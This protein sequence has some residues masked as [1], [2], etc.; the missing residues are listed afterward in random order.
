MRRFYEETKLD[1][2]TYPWQTIF[3]LNHIVIAKIYRDLR[4]EHHLVQDHHGEVPHIPCLTPEGFERWMTYMIQAHPT[5]EFCR[6]AIAV[7]EMPISNADDRKERLPKELSRRLFPKQDDIQVRQRCAAA[8]SADGQ[9]PLPKHTQ[10]P[11]P[12]NQPPPS[13]LQRERSSTT[14]NHRATYVRG[15]DSAIHDSSGDELPPRVQI[16]RE[17]KPYVAKE[18]TGK[19]YDDTSNATSAATLRPVVSESGIKPRAA[20]TVADSSYQSSSTRSSD[21]DGPTGSHH[22][23]TYSKTSSRRQRSPTTSNTYVKSD[24]NLVDIPPSYYTS[25]IY[26]DPLDSDPRYAKDAERDRRSARDTVSERDRKSDRDRDREKKERDRRDR[27]KYPSEAEL[28]Y[29]RR[30][31]EEED[32]LYRT[33]SRHEDEYF[34]RG[35]AAGSNGYADY[36]YPPPGP[37]ERRYG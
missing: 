37:G 8:L 14:D 1:D 5:H 17:R 36:Q 28:D 19:I 33:A 10:L 15:S 23:R 16:E 12:P 21:A 34:R 24:S 3:R 25:N 31:A 9:V 11:P 2:E 18:G 29:A 32:A 4:C 13:D 27:D 35:V 7:R 26:P 22:H 6:L 30:R 20:S